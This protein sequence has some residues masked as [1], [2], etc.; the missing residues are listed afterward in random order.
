MKLELVLNRVRGDSFDEALDLWGEVIFAYNLESV[1]LH[2][3]EKTAVD[4][5]CN[6][7][8]TMGELASVSMGLIKTT[9]EEVY[10]NLEIITEASVS[11]GESEE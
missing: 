8:E 2:L 9:R 4:G 11:E 5:E 1:M 10:R 3:K 6:L 7:N